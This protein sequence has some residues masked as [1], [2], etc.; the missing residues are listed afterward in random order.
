MTSL[1]RLLLGRFLLIALVP[2]FLL[3][4]V[5]RDAPHV[6]LPLG[7]VTL[8]A[9]LLAL[10]LAW[11]VARHLAEPLDALS[12]TV[13]RVHDGQWAEVPRAEG[14]ERL[15][16]LIREVNRMI[17][18]LRGRVLELEGGR[19]QLETVLGQMAD[20]LLVLDREGRVI[21]ANAAA[22]RLLDLER[23]AVT[24]RI[25]RSV[26]P[27]PVVEALARQVLGGE[28]A[29]PLELR[30]PSSDCTLRILATPLWPE[31]QPSQSPDGAVLLIQDLTEIRRLDRIRRDFVANVSHEL[32]T[33]IT[34]VRALAETLFLRAGRRPEIVPEYAERIGKEMERL[35]TLVEDLLTLSRIESGAR[36]ADPEEIDIEQIVEEQVSRFRDAARARSIQLSITPETAGVVRADRTSLEMVLANVLD[37]ALKYTPAGGRVEIQGEVRDG[38]GLF[39]V[40]DT[41]MGIPP[42]D[43]PR[44]FERFYRVDPAR[45]QEIEGTGLGL[46]IVKHLCENGGG[47][48]WVESELGRGSCFH[49][50][51]PAG[52]G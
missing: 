37:N 52:F 35:G 49:M 24:G 16:T 26:L 8:L 4:V 33:P 23:A 15:R 2:L 50:A 42:D 25:L 6:W 28:P 22:R 51:F 39:T 10:L 21:R 9:A 43:L 29:E 17:T 40:T 36:D 48:V 14:P 12:Y 5:L 13:Q 11:R 3:A 34:S 31:H 41:G 18:R 32:K 44:I 27:N 7:G 46:A 47:R 20:G 38:E 45:S 19:A 30:L 1:F